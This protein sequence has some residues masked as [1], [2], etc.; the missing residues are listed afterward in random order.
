MATSRQ[1]GKFEGS[2]LVPNVEAGLARVLMLEVDYQRATEA[3]K[4]ECSDRFDFTVKGAFDCIDTMEPKGQVDRCE[5]RKFVD[6]NIRWLS[7]A[8]LDSI[9]RRCDTDEDEAIS[10]IEFSELIRGIRPELTPQK[11][12]KTPYESASPMPYHNR[13]EIKHVYVR[14][15]TVVYNPPYM[16]R[17]EVKSTTH[18]SPAGYNYYSDTKPVIKASLRPSSQYKISTADGSPPRTI[19]HQISPRHYEKAYLPAKHDFSTEQKHSSYLRIKSPVKY[20]IPDKLHTHRPPVRV[21]IEEHHTYR[22]P[23]HSPIRH[24]SKYSPTKTITT[25]RHGPF[26]HTEI[27]TVNDSPLKGYEEKEFVE[28]LKDL[29]HLESSLERAKQVLAHRR[30]FTIQDAFRIFDVLCQGRISVMGIIDVF[31]LYGNFITHEDAKLIMSRFDRDRDERLTIEEF[32]DMFIPIDTVFASSLDGRSRKHPTGYYAT[33][34]ILDSITKSNFAYVLRLT[35]DVE[36]HVE[37]IRQKHSMRPLFNSADAF[38]AVNKFG[39]SPFH[40]YISKDDFSH[41][42]Q[43]HSFIA[44]NKELNMIMDRFDKN[45]DERVSF[46]EFVSELAPH[47]PSK[48]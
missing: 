3:V 38:N 12:Y 47:S 5:I 31:S 25:H 40:E 29:I 20:D 48:Y 43:K 27:H 30:D 41:L 17:E 24:I 33:T 28:S 19:I 2:S 4:L 10:Y 1:E 18:Y 11:T 21:E 7:E 35:L 16:P 44:T 9:I 23:R 34:D 26:S 45:K 15:I 6:E 42:L 14:P 39:G 37:G 8:E 32:S 22:S 46:G 36:R 13:T